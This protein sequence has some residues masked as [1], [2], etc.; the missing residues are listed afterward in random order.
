MQTSIFFNFHVERLDKRFNK[1]AATKP[2][3]ALHAITHTQT[4]ASLKKVN[5]FVTV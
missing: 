2:Q 4:K 5:E 3:K 1:E